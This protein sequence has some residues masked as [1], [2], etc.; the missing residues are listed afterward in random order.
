MSGIFIIEA[1]NIK[2][3]LKGNII[4]SVSHCMGPTAANICPYF[5]LKYLYGYI[6]GQ[7]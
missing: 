5:L 7:L 6:L 1:S 3:A 2:N 4:Y